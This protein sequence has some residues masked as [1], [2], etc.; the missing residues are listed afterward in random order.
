MGESNAQEIVETN[1]SSYNTAS[2]LQYRLNTEEIIK[3][4]EVFLRGE[5]ITYNVDESGEYKSVKVKIGEKKANDLGIQGILN[6]I[7]ALVNPQT[8]QGNF[9]RDQFGEYLFIVNINL[10]D[11]MVTNQYR[12]ELDDDDIEPIIDFIMDMLT[13][14]MSR[15]IDNKE[16]DSYGNSLVHRESN[17]L[18]KS[19]GFGIFRRD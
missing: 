7:S 11:M 8:V 4:I 9:K 14:F 10:A 3:K 5:I 17:T 13:P 12:W 6:Y 19:G 16:R 15:L 1:N 18:Q 2:V